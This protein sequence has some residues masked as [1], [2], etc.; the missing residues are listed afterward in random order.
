MVEKA[1]LINTA[2]MKMD[3]IRRELE[4]RIFIGKARR[5]RGTMKGRRRLAE[6]LANRPWFSAGSTSNLHEFDWGSQM[7]IILGAQSAHFFNGAIQLFC[8]TL[9]RYTGFGLMQ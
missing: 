2:A 7:R 1:K 5:V 6:R 3:C 8:G 9:L 4:D